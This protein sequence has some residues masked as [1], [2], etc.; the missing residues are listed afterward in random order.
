MK[1]KGG[2]NK[3]KVK[4]K[5]KKKKKNRNKQKRKTKTKTKKKGKTKKRL[6]CFCSVSCA[7]LFVHARTRR[8]AVRHIMIIVLKAMCN[9]HDLVE[10][11]QVRNVTRT[12]VVAQQA[13]DWKNLHDLHTR[14][15]D[16]LVQ[17]LQLGN[18][19][20]QQDRGDEPLRNDRDD[21]DELRSHVTVPSGPYRP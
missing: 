14:N 13:N 12:P 20:S 11:L 6:P 1:T 21:L 3:T 16:H 8:C 10:G 15:I 17:E 2:K 7:Q 4:K 18:L 5:K 9:V 19:H